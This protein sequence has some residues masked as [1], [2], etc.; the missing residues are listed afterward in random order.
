M[1]ESP[2][3][4]AKVPADDLPQPLMYRVLVQPITLEE[5]TSGGIVIA[6][7][8]HKA[9]SYVEYRAKLVAI[10]PYA[11]QKKDPRTGADLWPEGHRPQVGD[12]VV[13]ARYAGQAMEYRGVKLLVVND[14]EIL[15]RVKDPKSLKVYL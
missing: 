6:Q 5:T 12:Y 14:D 15:C 9:Q 11:F 10:G 8:S 4:G 13:C 2:D 7:E 3:A 1:D